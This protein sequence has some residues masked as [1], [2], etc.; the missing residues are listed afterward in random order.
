MLTFDPPSPWRRS[1][2][3]SNGGGDCVEVAA[4]I[5]SILLR[6]SKNPETE[7]TI[8]LR[9][10]QAFIRAVKQGDFDLSS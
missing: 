4:G 9:G 10:F 7:L 5:D 2:R 1:S 3:C 8:D 6:D